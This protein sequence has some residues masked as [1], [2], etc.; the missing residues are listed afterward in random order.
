[1]YEDAFM[2]Y[3]CRQYRFPGSRCFHSIRSLE[4][5]IRLSP[6][7]QQAASPGIPT[8]RCYLEKMDTQVDR[9]GNEKQVP[10]NPFYSE[11][12][13]CALKLWTWEENI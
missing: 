2:I 10:K 4:G 1:M 11:L 8:G 3:L 12:S 13:P 5:S 6:G 7:C 9:K